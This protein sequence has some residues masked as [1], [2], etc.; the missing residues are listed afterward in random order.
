VLFLLPSFSFFLPLPFYFTRPIPFYFLFLSLSLFC[1]SDC[2]LC[3]FIPL[4]S[5][6]YSVLS[7]IGVR[8]SGGTRNC[9]LFSTAATPTLGH[10]HLSIQWYEATA[11]L[12][13]RF[14]LEERVAAAWGLTLWFTWC[15]DQ[16]YVNPR[17][18]KVWY[19]QRKRNCYI[20]F[21]KERTF[22]AS[23][24]STLCTVLWAANTQSLSSFYIYRWPKLCRLLDTLLS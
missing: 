13:S 8:I 19:S 21:L 9:F 20:T 5:I 11:P 23:S 24:K 3:N 2:I 22:T 14:P 4:L 12:T 15:W 10:V 18:L 6:L 16:E 1:S 17:V 7:R